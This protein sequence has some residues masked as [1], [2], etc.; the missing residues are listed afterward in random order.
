MWQ[1]P[2]VKERIQAALKEGLTSQAV[3]RV[4]RDHGRWYSIIHGLTHRIRSLWKKGTHQ[5]EHTQKT[6]GFQQPKETIR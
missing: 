3:T 5:T 6:I 2:I 4:K 1:E